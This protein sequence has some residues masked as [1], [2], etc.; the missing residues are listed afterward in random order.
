MEECEI[1]CG[2]LAIMV[3]GQ[4]ECVGSPQHLKNKYGEGYMVSLKVSQEH[5]H[6]T[7]QEIRKHFPTV[8]L[9][10]QRHSMILVQIIQV[11]TL[12]VKC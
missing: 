2:R 5:Q 9:K 7:M 12:Q 8:V 10:E 11:D 6:V 1:L 4:F 3:N